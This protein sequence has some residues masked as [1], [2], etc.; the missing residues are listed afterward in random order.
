M[1]AQVA[2][3]LELT[4]KGAKEDREE[5]A[6]ADAGAGVAFIPKGRKKEAK[7]TGLAACVRSPKMPP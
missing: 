7:E 5:G 1:S 4:E 3:D 2:G 6:D